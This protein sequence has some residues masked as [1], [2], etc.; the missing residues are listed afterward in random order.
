MEIIVAGSFGQWPINDMECASGCI[1]KS[2]ESSPES[3]VGVGDRASNPRWQVVRS[4]RHAEPD[5]GRQL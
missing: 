2:V 3:G 4:G 1:P 5:T